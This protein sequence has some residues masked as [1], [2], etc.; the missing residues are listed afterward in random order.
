[1]GENSATFAWTPGGQ[2]AGT[3]AIRYKV[4]DIKK[5]LEK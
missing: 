3:Y 2:D 5:K 4:K 1:V